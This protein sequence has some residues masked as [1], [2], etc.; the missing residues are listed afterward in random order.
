MFSQSNLKLI[1]WKKENKTKQNREHF[2]PDLSFWIQEKTIGK[3]SENKGLHRKL[4]LCTY[5]FLLIMAISEQTNK[6]T[7]NWLKSLLSY[8]RASWEYFDRIFYQRLE[9]VSASKKNVLQKPD[10]IYN[11]IS[12]GKR[13]S[14]KVRKF[15]FDTFQLKYLARFF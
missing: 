11:F 1:S 10:K 9:N 6:P 8:Y 3:S 4:C 14:V 5:I 15:C 12:G 13:H 2:H 7:F